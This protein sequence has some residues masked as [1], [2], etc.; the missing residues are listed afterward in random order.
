MANE[1]QMRECVRDKVF[2]GGIVQRRLHSVRGG[3]KRHGIIEHRRSVA[4]LLP[5][6]ESAGMHHAFG[7]SFVVEMKDLLPEVESPRASSG[8]GLP[9]SR[10]SG[11]L[12][13][14]EHWGL[15]TGR[16]MQ[17]FATWLVGMICSP[18]S[19][20][21]FHLSSSSPLLSLP[22]VLRKRSCVLV[23]I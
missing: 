4:N 9:I 15:P 13:C 16:L 12:L 17:L 19:R 8:P 10:S 1:L 3:K 7:T 6:A 21:R 20:R 11:P 22:S 23:T 14:C 5:G 18:S 2:R